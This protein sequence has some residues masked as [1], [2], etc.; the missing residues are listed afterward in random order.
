MSVRVAQLRLEANAVMISTA[1]V[2]FYNNKT[3]VYGSGSLKPDFHSSFSLVAS[4]IFRIGHVQSGETNRTG[5][6]NIFRS[7]HN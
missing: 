3:D 7:V 1:T 6:K 5:Q 4:E 2:Y